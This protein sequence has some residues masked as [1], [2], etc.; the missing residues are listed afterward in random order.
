MTIS[1]AAELTLATILV[2]FASVFLICFMEGA[3][4][5]D[6]HASETVPP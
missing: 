1:S 2:A 5:G 6:A 4:G 3:F